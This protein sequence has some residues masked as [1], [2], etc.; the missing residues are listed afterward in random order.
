[1]SRLG[2][3]CRLAAVGTWHFVVGDTPEFLAAVAMVVGAAL[4]LHHFQPAEWIALPGLVVSVLAG[5][6]WWRARTSGR[7]GR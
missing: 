5:S 6:V 1:M 3:W 4:V 2:R 7:D